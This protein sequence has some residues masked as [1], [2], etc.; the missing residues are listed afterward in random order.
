[1]PGF[2]E[3]GPG[4][5]VIAS[6]KLLDSLP[7]DL[8]AM[9]ATAADA[10]AIETLGDFTYHNAVSLRVLVEEHGVEVLTFPEP[11]VRRLKE[12]SEA[13]LAE[14]ATSDPLTLRVAES[15]DAFLAQAD[16]YAPYA[17]QGILTWRQLD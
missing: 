5:E 9:V 10:T 13:V 3:P 6:R 8:R 17:E 16:D 1:M 15:Y 4:L 11:V 7:D 14:I 2:H 12:V